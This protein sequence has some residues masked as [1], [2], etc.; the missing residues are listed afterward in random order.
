MKKQTLNI[1]GDNFSNIETFYDEIDR[2]LTKGLNWKTGHNFDSFNDILRGGFGVYE[3]EEPITIIWTSISK[4]RLTLGEKQIS[5]LLEIITTH[6]HIEL[7][8]K[9]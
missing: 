1:N 2:V 7:I 6:Q 3:F 8:T 9:D 5:T 4:S